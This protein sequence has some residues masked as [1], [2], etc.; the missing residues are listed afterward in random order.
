MMPSEFEGLPIV[1]DDYSIEFAIRYDEPVCDKCGSMLI[2]HSFEKQ[3]WKFWCSMCRTPVHRLT[4]ILLDR[5]INVP[6]KFKTVDDPFT[7]RE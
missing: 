5:K 3:S 1:A 6:Q 2:T 4:M 7:G